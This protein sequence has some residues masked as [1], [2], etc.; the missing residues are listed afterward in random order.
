MT[1]G[2][3]LKLILFFTLP[4]LLGNI[5]QQFY[6]MADTFIVSQTLG[7]NALAAVGSTGSI[8]FLILGLA[9]GISA[10]LAVITAQR[11]GQRDDA[12]L[13][14]S[15]GA[16]LIIVIISS[17]LITV[18]ATT[19]TR[20]ILE[21]MQTPPEIIDQAYDYLV[22]IFAGIGI[23]VLFNYLSNILRAIGDSRTPLIFLIIAS[24]LNVI[25][26]YLFILGFGMDVEGAGYAT[27]ISQIV[28]T[29]LCLIY[30][31]RRVPSLRVFKEDWTLQWSEYSEHLRI[32]LPFGFQNS[33]IAIG[34][35]AVQITL[36][37]L[38]ATSV[39]AFT[40][41]SKINQL[42]TMPLQT[43]GVA[44]STYVAQN[45]GAKKF[46]RIK[47][48]VRSVL[49]IGILYSIGVG[50]FLWFFGR[51]LSSIFVDGNSE[52]VLALTDQ[53]FKIHGPFYLFLAL[54]FILRS[55]LQGLGN[56]FAP[57]LSSS[58]ELIARVFGAITLSHFFDYNGAIM[59]NPLA[60]I[61]AIVILVPAYFSTERLITNQ[62][63]RWARRFAFGS[64]KVIQISETE[65]S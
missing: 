38:G 48:G 39:M 44:M 24:I 3:P 65:N 53:Y 31:K 11:F 45:F 26:D 57:T 47:Y 33:I 19:N 58:M 23:T 56:S 7:M 63:N 25:L 59:S 10:G 21:L 1:S 15:L 43:L 54:I 42:L 8:N 51:T 34:S 37:R 61:S 6:S 36:N 28:A 14:R 49:K 17:I 22:V 5:F 2:N 50:I 32:A 30:I 64:K 4:M 52:V 60:W 40:A 27:I 18:L 41:A 20:R 62:P 16:G 29:I 9:I 35:I 46:E 55:S 12:G 13:R